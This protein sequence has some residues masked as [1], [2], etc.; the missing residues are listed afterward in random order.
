MSCRVHFP[1]S[2]S[3][4]SRMQ[5]L[6]PGTAFQI[7]FVASPHLQPSEDIWIRFY[8]LKF[9]TLPR[10]FNIVMYAGHLCKW[11]QNR[12]WWWW[13]WTSWSD[14][15]LEAATW[16]RACLCLQAAICL[17]RP[18]LCLEISVSTL[19]TVL[20]QYRVVDDKV[21]RS[22]SVC[23]VSLSSCLN[24]TLLRA[25][26]L[27]HWL[28]VV[29]TV[30]NT[31]LSG[32]QRLMWHHKFI[33]RPSQPPRCQSVATSLRFSIATRVKH[34]NP[35]LPIVLNVFLYFIHCVS[36]ALDTVEQGIYYY[37]VMQCDKVFV[38]HLKFA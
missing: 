27:G 1:S 38:S 28:R 13:W 36:F 21:K 2:V 31:L 24:F 7:T 25:C 17:T 6:L 11:T 5:D 23:L 9:L 35:L 10:T 29:K 20:W 19:L 15:V 12:R 37:A 4:P 16:L 3:R 22:T 32:I 18:S 26:S 8:S 30:L 14:V 33:C 34:C